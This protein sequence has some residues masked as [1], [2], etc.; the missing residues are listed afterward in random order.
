MNT[1]ICDFV[2]KYARSSAIRLHMPGHKGV[3]V[4][5][6]EPLD[7]TEI[8][9]ADVLYS[10]GGIIRESEENAAKLFGAARTVYST[11]GSSLSIR[12]MLYLTALYAKENG[13]RPII[14]AGRNAH[15]AF[16]SAAALID[17]EVVWLYSKTRGNM[18]SCDITAALLDEMLASMT[19]LPC[20]VYITSPNYLGGTADI[21]GLSLVCHKHGVLLLVDNAHGAYLNFL[22][23]SRHPMALGADM[24]ADSAHKTLPV[25]TGGAYL[26]ISKTAPHMFAEQCER[27]MA[28]F[29]STSPSYLIL[30]SL[31][32]A[33]RYLS[34]GYRQRLCKYE[35]GII[36]LKASMIRHGYN[37][38]QDEALKLTILTKMVGYLGHEYAQKLLEYNVVC[39]F[40]DPDYCVLMFTPELGDDILT[41]LERVIAEIPIKDQIT[42]GSPHAVVSEAVMTPREAMLSPSE[43]IPVSAALGRVLADVNVSC[44][45]AI[46][47]VMCGEQIGNDALRAFEYYGITSVRVVK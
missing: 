26:H 10:S 28:L 25:L 11:E 9:G 27:A 5:G 15:K 30:Q 21:S 47:I 35:R 37:V 17:F 41:R 2:K 14:A 23:E 38:Y 20:A 18:I 42:A 45:P 4:L 24:C 31:D 13:K 36:G 39:E 3:P 1:P 40:S 34:S 29:A 16:L 7:I 33:N 6:A 8:D 46:P 12:A 32:S 22:S 44:P 43:V 19:E